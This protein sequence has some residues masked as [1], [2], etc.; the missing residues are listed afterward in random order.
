MKKNYGVVVQRTNQRKRLAWGKEVQVG[1]L[2]L[3]DS[4][5]F[6]VQAGGVCCVQ[7]NLEC[8]V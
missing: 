2:Q 8:F 1:D 7:I 4:L 3:E 6:T 5:I